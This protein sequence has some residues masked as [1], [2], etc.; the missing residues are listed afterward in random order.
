MQTYSDS[1]NGALLVLRLIMAV[2]FF[3]AGY[4]K[5][6][7]WSDVPEGMPAFLVPI[8][9]LLSICEPLGALALVGGFLTRWAALGLSLVLL[10]AIAVTQFV[11]G[12]GFVTPTAPGWNFP[13]AVLGGCIALMA[14]G[15]GRWSI[16]AARA[17]SSTQR[18]SAMS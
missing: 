2:T 11:F 15:A 13:F 4:F 7:F 5:L 18:A 10:G 12:I 8:M 14:F 3:V 16:D 9:R 17:G 6:P 1:Q